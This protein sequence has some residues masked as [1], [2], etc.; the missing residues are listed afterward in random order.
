MATWQWEISWWS[1]DWT[2]HLYFNLT[3]VRGTSKRNKGINC[4]IDFCKLQSFCLMLEWEKWWNTTL[5]LST[6]PIHTGFSTRTM[7]SNTWKE[8]IRMTR[9]LVQLLLYHSKGEMLSR[10]SQNEHGKETGAFQKT[11]QVFRRN[12]LYQIEGDV[13]KI[14]WFQRHPFNQCPA[15]LKK[16]HIAKT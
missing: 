8:H 3:L 2:N 4:C 12:P 11:C 9:L 16:E 5:P 1:V 14:S 6:W 13:W 15:V 7:Q 10:K